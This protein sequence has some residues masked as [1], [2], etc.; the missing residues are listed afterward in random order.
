MNAI[1]ITLVRPRLIP[2]LSAMVGALIA[3]YVAL[4]V[5]TIV[6]ASLQTHLAQEVQQKQMAIG[7]LESDY[8]AQVAQLG[9]MDPKSLG[10][11]KP[12]RVT[13]LTQASLPGL[14]FAGN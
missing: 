2:T 7:K 12:T 3:V 6:F 10:Y 14:T 11:V 13:Y 1:A 4:M 8:Y 9:A 5:T